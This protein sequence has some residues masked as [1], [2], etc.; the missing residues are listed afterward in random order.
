M[1]EVKNDY[2]EKAL[3]ELI[4]TLGIKEFIDHEKLIVLIGSKKVKEAIKGI[5]LYLGLPIEVNISYVP[6]GYRPSSN[7]GFQSTHLV[8]TDQH[9]RGVGGITA[10]VSIPPNLPF[11]GS[12][13]MVN[14]PIN[15]RLSENCAENPATLISIMAHELSHI[16]LYSLWNREKENEF[17]TDLTAM[18]LGFANI[19]KTGRKVVKVTQIPNGTHTQTTT[20]GYLSDDNF[21]YAFHK[22]N[23]VLNKQKS[24]KK[25]LARKLKQLKKKLNKIKKL[26]FYFESYL[27]YLDKNLHQKISQEDGRKI[28][29]F[30]QP[31]HTDNF[32]STI[33]KNETILESFIKFVENLKN[34][35][36]KNIEV[37]KQQ[38]TQLKS[39]NEELD[40]QRLLLQNDLDV[41][42]KYIGFFYRLKL[43]FT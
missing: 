40:K 27:A 10:Q 2:I 5:A 17:Y 20:Y 4:P 16:V 38:E 24:E 8:K 25:K 31:G 7:D 12:P 3:N 33:R 9:N 26:S 37:M 23:G 39:A 42:K 34:Y 18:I 13:S 15:V 29:A 21:N 6:K 41:L 30:H 19:M 28:M 32:Q 22:I 43:K 14:F 36:G 1:E 11:Y 35:T